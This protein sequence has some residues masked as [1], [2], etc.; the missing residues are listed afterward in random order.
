MLLQ[1]IGTC[2]K[3]QILTKKRRKQEENSRTQKQYRK[4]LKKLEKK[5]DQFTNR[6]TVQI[7]REVLSR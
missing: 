6:I 5:N 4:I 3:N 1:E 7:S 2:V